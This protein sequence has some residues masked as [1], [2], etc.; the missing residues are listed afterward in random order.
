MV[1]VV[2]PPPLGCVVDEVVAAVDDVVPE[3]DPDPE[4]DPEI[5]DPLDLVF[6]L[7]FAF[8]TVVV[9]VVLP[10]EVPAGG[11]PMICSACW[12]ACSMAAMSAW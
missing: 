6:A 1:D 11:G 12:I 8:G 4:P 7:A 9:V 2:V 10:L 5:P 3:P